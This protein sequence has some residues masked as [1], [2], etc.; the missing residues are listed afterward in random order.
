MQ[1]QHIYNL[2]THRPALVTIISVPNSWNSSQSGFISSWA[3][4]LDSE[5]CKGNFFFC[6][7]A[8][9]S[10]IVVP[11]IDSVLVELSTILTLI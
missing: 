10:G 7:G 6:G 1:T 4:T 11:S 3:T 2:Y 8:D 5:V 9:C